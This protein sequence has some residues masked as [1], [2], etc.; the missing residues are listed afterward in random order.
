MPLKISQG[1]WVDPTPKSQDSD[2]HAWCPLKGHTYLNKPAGFS[3]RFVKVFMT[4]YWTP[5]VKKLKSVP[6]KPVNKWLW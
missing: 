2:A 3:C 5:G 1:V 6:G 4:C